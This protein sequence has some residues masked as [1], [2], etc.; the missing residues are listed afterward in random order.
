MLKWAILNVIALGLLIPLGWI[1]VNTY[2]GEADPLIHALK[3]ISIVMAITVLFV[4]T[5]F[6][7]NEKMMAFISTL[8][9]GLI[10]WDEI[11]VWWIGK[12]FSLRLVS[13]HGLNIF[14]FILVVVFAV[15]AWIDRYKRRHSYDLD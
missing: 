15:L 10:A 4:R 7:S 9:M 1:E 5:R 12:P 6:I 14:V 3:F 11:H 13:E 2:H 8:A